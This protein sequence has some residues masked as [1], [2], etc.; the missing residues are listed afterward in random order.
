MRSSRISIGAASLLFV[1]PKKWLR[2]QEIKLALPVE[3]NPAFDRLYTG[4]IVAILYDSFGSD[5]TAGGTCESFND[6]NLRT[7]F[8]QTQPPRALPSRIGI[9]NWVGIS[10]KIGVGSTASGECR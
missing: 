7:L 9:G 2:S 6:R 10:R 4:S 3:I 8:W 1:Y 5:S